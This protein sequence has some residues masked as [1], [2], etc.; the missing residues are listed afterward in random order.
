MRKAAKRHV[1]VGVICILLMSA[2]VASALAA[3]T[4]QERVAQPTGTPAVGEDWSG[5]ILFEAVRYGKFVIKALNLRS[6]TTT[7]LTSAQYNSYSPSWLPDGVHIGFVSD[8]DGRPEIYT[9]LADGSNV[10]QITRNRLNEQ[11]PSWSPDG[12]KLIYQIWPEEGSRLTLPQ[13][14]I[15]NL[16]TLETEQLTYGPGGSYD[17]SW[18]PDG[19]YI[20]FMANPDGHPDIYR[21]SMNDGEIVRLTH[22]VFPVTHIQ[23]YA[24]SWSPDGKQIA[25]LSIRKVATDIYIMDFDGHGI[26]CITCGSKALRASAPTWSPD[27]EQIAFSSKGDIC[28]MNI[29]NGEWNCLEHTVALDGSWNSDWR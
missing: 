22:S 7:Q 8:R 9:M 4:T 2:L 21:M 18:S 19:E 5:T 26:R 13:L 27:G 28:I 12:K 6:G 23:N 15:T 3:S 24:P 10:H 1:L 25:F 17:P 29:G 14:Y 20:V 11:S 16:E